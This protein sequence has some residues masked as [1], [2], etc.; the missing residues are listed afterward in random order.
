MK[1]K[2]APGVFGGTNRGRTR[3]KIC[4]IT[5]SADAS[6]AIQAGADAL[7]FNFYPKSR[8]FLDPNAVRGWLEH[9]PAYIIRIA[10]LVNPSLEQALEI[11]AQPFIDALQLHGD[12]SP[13]FCRMLA[14]REIRFIKVIRVRN[15][16]SLRDVPSYFTQTILL[17]SDSAGWGGS[18][19]T[20]PWHLAAA[21]AQ[22]RPD[23]QIAIA[24]GLTPENV[25]DAIHQVRPCAVD[26]TSG[27]ESSPGKKDGARMRAFVQAAKAALG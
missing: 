20:F 6:D 23:L 8:R 25:A 16:D 27:T 7:G 11:A 24:G 26:V 2:A 18:G 12:E 21:F 5:S 22:A 14:D 1:D 10:V 3:V 15:E 17:D 19:K 9:L 4:G 13:E